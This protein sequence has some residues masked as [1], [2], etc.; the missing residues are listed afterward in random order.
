VGYAGGSQPEPTYRALGDHTECF[1]VDYDPSAISYEQLLELFWDS[2][3]PMLRAHKVQYASLILAA[4][5]EQLATA[6]AS[7]AAAR[8][9]FGAD[10]V[11]RIERLG[12]FWS[13]EDY[14]QK[15]YLRNDRSLMREFTALCADE[16]AFV[17]STA[18]ARING[19]VA[20]D[21][22][23]EQLARMIDSFGL[24]EEGRRCLELRVGDTPAGTECRIR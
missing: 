16:A 18:A 12:E 14:H 23:A 13:A 15:Y 4:D 11:T 21:G 1:Q 24:S 20:G 22:T 9:R 2:H 17:D 10:P 5:D 7:R 6:L 19:F 3:N 8:A